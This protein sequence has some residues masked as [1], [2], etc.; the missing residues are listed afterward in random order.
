MEYKTQSLSFCIDDSTLCLDLF[1][2]KQLFIF[3]FFLSELKLKIH[4]MKPLQGHDDQCHFQY[5][6]QGKEEWYI[7][8]K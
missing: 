6:I 1:E 2:I 5:F 4:I 8:I 7:S 3:I